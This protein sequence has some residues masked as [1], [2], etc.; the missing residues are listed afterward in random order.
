VSL[1]KMLAT[2]A[3]PGS[4]SLLKIR[5]GFHYSSKMADE[6]SKSERSVGL[7]EKPLVLN[8]IIC[9]SPHP[10][11]CGFQL[12]NAVTTVDSGRGLIR[13]LTYARR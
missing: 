6:R 11:R 13:G 10:K 5:G 8:S 2:H 9:L 1:L 4:A 12:G 3:K 7:P